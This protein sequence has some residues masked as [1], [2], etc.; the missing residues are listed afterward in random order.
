[1]A[2]NI[3]QAALNGIQLSPDNSPGYIHAGGL[4]EESA[5]KTSELLTINHTAYHTR[6]K[7]TFHR[8]S[9]SEIQDMWEYNESY[10]TPIEREDVAASRPLDLK[11]AVTFE[12]CLGDND[13]YADFV[14]FFRDEIAE[15]GVPAFIK[16]YLLKGDERANDI[17]SRMYTDLVH[18]MIH[19]GCAL[20]FNQ[21]SLIAEA[22]AGACV[23]QNWPKQF[24]M[25]AE[26]YSRTHP[27]VPSKSLLQIYDGLHNDPAIK[28]GVREDDPFNKIPDGFLKRVTAD[29]L[30]PYLAQFQVKP[31]P[32]DLEHKL[33]EMMQT[34]AYEL[35]A[36]QRPGKRE[37]IDFVTLHSVTLS[38]FYPAILAQDWLSNHDKA[39]LLEAKARV[40]AVM[41]AGTGSP[42]LYPARVQ[43]YMPQRPGDG[44]PELFHRSIVYRDEGHAAKLIR[45][46]W[47]LEQLS[48]PAPDFPIAKKDFLKIAHLSMDSIERA[49]DETDGHKMPK[50]VAETVAK[51]I[52]VGGEMVSNNM[53]RWVFYGGLDKAWE[54]IPELEVSAA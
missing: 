27:D 8:A 13:R 47:S 49:F 5:S 24:L 31:E 22:F 15:K 41:Y 33:I 4:T 21:P 38:V 1:M 12:N 28:S 16:E 32:E 2:A 20:E 6:W 34:C 40:D 29:Q 10:Q 39:R 19:L 50:H 30:A 45:S 42:A 44:W 46:L 3:S 25:P 7:Q 23:H 48:D 52:G 11:D 35:G 53:T 37:A 17:F 54:I 36:A 43:N 18:P 9:P 26:E 51:N 14:R